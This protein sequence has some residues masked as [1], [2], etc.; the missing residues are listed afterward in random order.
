LLKA[1]A[2]GDADAL[3]DILDA[4]VRVDV[5]SGDHDD[6]DRYYTG[7]TAPEFW[8]DDRTALMVVAT[9]GYLEAVQFL[10]DRGAFSRGDT[11]QLPRLLWTDSLV[12][13]CTLWEG[14]GSEFS[15][16]EGC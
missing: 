12:Q 7:K 6:D 16:A 1:A 11:G 9:E 10:L 15:V 8:A 2:A 3:K 5:T 4:G 13:S 14:N